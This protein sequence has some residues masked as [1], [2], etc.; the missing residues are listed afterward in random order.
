MIRWRLVPTSSAVHD[1]ASLFIQSFLYFCLA[2]SRQFHRPVDYDPALAK[3][4]YQN[5]THSHHSAVHNNTSSSSAYKS[6]AAKLSDEFGF[7]KEADPD[8]DSEENNSDQESHDNDNSSVAVRKNNKSA[9]DEELSRALESLRLSNEAR[10]RAES[11]L[12]AAEVKLEEFQRLSSQAKQILI[13]Q[14]NDKIK[15]LQTQIEQHKT[16]LDEDDATIIQLKSK[17]LGTEELKQ[18]K[19][20]VVVTRENQTLKSKL[21]ELSN[22]INN[23]KDELAQYKN[24]IE[25]LKLQLTTSASSNP[26]ASSSNK[27]EDLSLIKKYEAEREIFRSEIM[28]KTAE[29]NKLLEKLNK[30]CDNKLNAL[31]DGETSFIDYFKKKFTQQ[32]Q[33]IIQTQEK[34]VIDEKKLN[35]LKSAYEAQISTLQA[36]YQEQTRQ[37][38][39]ATSTLEEEMTKLKADLNHASSQLSSQQQSL[40]SNTATQSAALLAAQQQI[41]SLKIEKNNLESALNDMN[42]LMQKRES[43]MKSVKEKAKEKLTTASDAIKKLKSEYSNLKSQYQLIKQ[44]NQSNKESRGKRKEMFVQLQHFN[45][46]NRQAIQAIKA[47]FNSLNTSLFQSL[48]SLLT[49][50]IN[51]FLIGQRAELT[52]L[53]AAYQREFKLRKQLFNQIQELKG[54][55]RVYCRVRPLSSRENDSQEN[56]I[57]YPE[58]DKLAI[59][60]AEKKISHSFEF[61]KIFQPNSTQEQVFG[62]I[63]DLV[64]SVMDGFN[65]CIFAYGQTGTG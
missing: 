33:T 30:L 51:T 42:A 10:L 25:K 15:L 20:S 32:A 19:D 60:N 23:Q 49:T 21:L 38:T 9:N 46:A 35:Q 4:L 40:H 52:N 24:E 41:N 54:N 14:F 26:T 1:V 17:S 61:E 6:K 63:A 47:D 64:T 34:L 22:T 3:Q 2:M 36:N 11:S 48:H 29:R 43:E 53:A 56:C 27:G 12:S 18:F 45:T 39:S 58:D 59:D 57:N 8:V 50:Q 5:N 13:K 55:I 62:E 28:A 44:Y 7:D 31:E 16:S 65:V 37:F